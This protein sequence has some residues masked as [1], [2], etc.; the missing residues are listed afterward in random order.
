MPAIQCG[1]AVRLQDILP[2]AGLPPSGLPPDLHAPWFGQDSA[3]QYRRHGGHPMY[4]ASDID[5]RLN[6]LG[7][8]GPAFEAEASLRIA[9]VGC[10]W[11]FG[12]GLP[13]A[14]LFHQRFAQRVAENVGRTA[15]AFNLG[16]PGASNDAIVRLLHQAVP[17]LKPHVVLVLFTHAARREYIA[18]SN[19]HLRYTPTATEADP[20]AQE[21]AGHFTALTSTYDDRLNLWRNYK[22][23]EALLSRHMWCFSLVRPEDAAL[24]RDHLDGHRQAERHTWFD[25]ARDHAH[26]GPATHESL[27]E[28]F[29]AAF[30]R[31]NGPARLRA[32]MVG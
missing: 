3:D 14:T 27:C 31:Q 5:Y 26:P 28:A 24:I 16:V 1:E 13:E 4:G 30:T 10:S 8:R 11:V 6:A 15:V 21:I 20:I 7:Y 25:T 18:A 32:E 23:A 17:V 29:W 19:R 2:A 9:A 12:T 22:S